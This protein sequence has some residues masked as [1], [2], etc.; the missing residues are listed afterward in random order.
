MPPVSQPEA[1]PARPR[2]AARRLLASARVLGDGA[3]EHVL[4]ASRE[5]GIAR[6]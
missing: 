6:Q 1:P 5:I 3:L 4:K 2:R